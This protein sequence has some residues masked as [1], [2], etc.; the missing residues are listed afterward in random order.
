MRCVELFPV[1]RLSLRVCDGHV[2][3]LDAFGPGGVGDGVDVVHRAVGLSG[4]GA[5][6]LD[7]NA[8]FLKLLIQTLILLQHHVLITGGQHHRRTAVDLGRLGK[9]VDAFRELLCLIEIET[10]KLKRYFQVVAADRARARALDVVIE[11]ND[12]EILSGLL[13]V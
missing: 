11:I 6:V 9:I 12:A 8:E 7:W 3:G 1:K 4:N 10:G 5:V 2:D 13:G